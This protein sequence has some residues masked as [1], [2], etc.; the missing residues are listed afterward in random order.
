LKHY[1][2]ELPSHSGV[3]VCSFNGPPL[4]VSLPPGV[5]GR[6]CYYDQTV[7]LS[8]D[9]GNDAL[10]RLAWSCAADNLIRRPPGVPRL[11]LDNAY[12]KKL[13]RLWQ[14]WLRIVSN[15]AI[16]APDVLDPLAI[17]LTSNNPEL[18]FNAIGRVLC[19]WCQDY[20]AD[21][22]GVHCWVS[23]SIPK[24]VGFPYL[25]R[26]ESASETISL[27]M[28]ERENHDAIFALA[29]MFVWRKSISSDARPGLLESRWVYWPSA[30]G[31]RL[32]IRLFFQR[33]A[34]RLIDAPLIDVEC[35]RATPI[36]GHNVTLE[37]ASP[38]IDQRI[39]STRKE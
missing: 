16:R 4:D 36:N 10:N 14:H 2:I 33:P 20:P 31:P 24:G 29:A 26:P 9:T 15:L 12:H 35:V 5:T 21:L 1:S 19:H 30:A 34:T 28:P 7:P 11:H 38:S 32:S 13:A 17:D 22:W 8:I 25:T 23:A 37:S 18:I 27:L 3:H 6:P 39:S